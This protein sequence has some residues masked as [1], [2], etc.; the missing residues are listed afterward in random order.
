VRRIEQATVKDLP[1]NLFAHAHFPF[2]IDGWTREEVG[3][4]HELGNYRAG[5]F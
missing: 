2:E 5:V 1:G 4:L 3:R